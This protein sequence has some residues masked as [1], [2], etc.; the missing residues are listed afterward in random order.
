[1][2]L[3]I[4]V[5]KTS[6]V[7]GEDDTLALTST[8][9]VP[10]G[11]VLVLIGTGVYNDASVQAPYLSSVADT[12]SN[13]WQPPINV[14]ASGTFYPQVFAALAYNVAAGTP[15]VTGTFTL[16]TSGNKFSAALLEITGAPTASA[17]D[18][19][20]NATAT[21]G[22]SITTAA[23]GALAQAANVL[24]A[25][26]GGWIG[27]PTNPGGWSSALT[28][29]NGVSLGCQIS[30]KT[31]NDAASRTETFTTDA[32]AGGAILMLVIK[33]AATSALRYKF[34]LDTATF[35]SAD[36]GITGF[37][38]SNAT[39]DTGTAQKFTSL[40]GGA[41]AGD[42][43]IDT[44]LPADISLSDTISGIFYNGTDTSGL[45]AGTVEA[46]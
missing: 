25:C 10:A 16:S 46:A 7:T 41:T 17:L 3:A 13:T 9:A 23:T 39:P 2:A 1:M 8:S 36:T 45:I 44:D 6:V 34:A 14:R 24:V 31:I 33:Q 35:T 18:K 29:N 43:I 26:F 5:L 32:I 12:S 37:V 11:A 4:R 38:W 28:Q 15:T 30:Y 19:S 21:S 27:N 42:L 20:V 22:A 40:A